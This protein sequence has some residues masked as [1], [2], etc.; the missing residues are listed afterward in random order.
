LSSCSSVWQCQ[1]YTQQRNEI[2]IT[3]GHIGIGATATV[4]IPMCAAPDAQGKIL[5]YA[6]LYSSAAQ[7]VISDGVL[8]TV[9]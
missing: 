2:V 7:P 5:A 8:T 3:L 1:T 9:Q 6:E 4:Q